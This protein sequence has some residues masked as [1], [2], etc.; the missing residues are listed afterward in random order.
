M[1][2]QM[3]LAARYLGGRK[4]RTVLT[5]L[6]IAFGVLVIFGLNILLPSFGQALQANLMAMS[7]QVDTTITLKTSDTFNALN[8]QKTASVE[9]VSNVS[10]YLNRIMNI[11]ENY[12]GDANLS[13]FTLLGINPEQ[14]SA[15]HVYLVQKGSFLSVGDTQK[16]VITE[17]LADTLALQIGDSLRLPGVNGEVTLQIV[18]ILPPHAGPGNEEIY[19]TLPD[20]QAIFNLPGQVNTI[21]VNFDTLDEKRR[22]EIEENIL[23]VLGS[24]FQSGTL[25]ANSELLAN[26]QTGQVVLNLLG[27]LSLLM[28]GFIIFNTF[29]TL[30]AERRRD[31]GMLRALGATRS[32]VSHVILYEGLAQGLIGT[33]LGI[34]LGYLLAWGMTK[35]LETVMQQFFNVSIGMPVFSIW[36]LLGSAALGIGVTLLAGWL[37]ARNASR[38]TPLEALRP[39]FGA[40]TMKQIIGPAFWAG[41]GMIAVALAALLTQEAAFL[42]VGGALFITGLV[43]IAPTLINPIANLIGNLLA[44]VFARSGTAHLAQGNITRQP[45]RAAITASTIMIGMAILVTAAAMISSM[46]LGF[47]S[48]IRRNLGSDYLLVPPSVGLWGSNVGASAMLDEE[49]AKVEG[50]GAVSGLR[51][52]PSLVNDI[53]FSLVS[54]DPV[55]YPQVSGLDFTQ[56]DEAEAYAALAE[57]RNMIVNGILAMSAGV[58]VGDEIEIVTPTGTQIYHVVALGSDMFNIKISTGYISHANLEADFQHTETMF[59]QI[60][61]APQADEEAVDQ[62]LE[63]L[64][65]KYPQFTLFKGKAYIDQ[66]LELI[67]MAFSGIIALVIFLSVPSLIAMVNTLAIG[68]I[69]RTREIGMLR[70]VGA[71][72]KQVRTIIVIEALI[73]S[74]LGTAFGM[75]AGLY[76]GYMAVTTLKGLGFPMEFAFPAAGVL[77]AIAASI[78]LG[79]IAAVIPSRQAARLQIVEALRYE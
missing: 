22:Q 10:G 7:G 11:P 72:R 20:A 52:A 34:L 24:N 2:I 77:V 75:L 60:N 23:S 6:A 47:E 27:V 3:T 50:V 53:P 33:A 73:L 39:V 32:M 18:G 63:T 74:V 5:T 29:R 68:V 8:V 15:M 14:A 45:T 30:V 37:P 59:V 40:V 61:L 9:G 67:R 49:L 21:E 17:S 38:I 51:Y 58:K 66:M 26:L 25:E 31:I 71:T 42:G 56:G 19:V 46:V 57:G 69:E 70:A 78:L 48:V 16:A 41:A 1:N 13:A 65:K 76:L 54:I 12:Y 44:V 4:L 55:K 43:L 36:L 79:L 64:M 28:G 62:A 35:V